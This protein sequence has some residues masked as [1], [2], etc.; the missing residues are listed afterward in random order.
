MKILRVILAL[1]FCL[2]LCSCKSAEKPN[3][4]NMF[5]NYYCASSANLTITDKSSKPYY[6]K[7]KYVS[8]SASKNLRIGF[9]DSDIVLFSDGTAMAKLY[10]KI[11]IS[12]TDPEFTQIY[13]GY[14]ANFNSGLLMTALI[15]DKNTFS[16]GK[17]DF[18]EFEIVNAL[19]LECKYETFNAVGAALLFTDPGAE[20]YVEN[21]GG[22]LSVSNGEIFYYYTSEDGACL[23]NIKNEAAVSGE[24]K[25]NY[26]II[27]EM[28]PA[29]NMSVHAVL[30]TNS[31]VFLA[32]MKKVGNNYIFSEEN[33]SLNTVS[34][35]FSDYLQN[36]R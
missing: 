35:S 5:V 27:F 34:V 12:V 31:G 30:M 8:F 11:S 15:S 1:A 4:A 24:N 36:D 13:G 10:S 14:Y 19:S 29:E 17:F 16:P 20:P 26:N 9:S 7:N 33:P 25:K 6:I 32:P 18:D 21:K 28:I 23:S 2:T 22:K 3:N